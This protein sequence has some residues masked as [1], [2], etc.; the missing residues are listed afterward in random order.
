LQGWPYRGNGCDF[1]SLVRSAGSNPDIGVRD[2][3]DVG[4]SRTK[5][6]RASGRLS[7]MLAQRGFHMKAYEF[8]PAECAARGMVNGQPGKAEGS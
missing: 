6:R 1:V 8:L 5:D 2:Y 7:S 3:S 4:P